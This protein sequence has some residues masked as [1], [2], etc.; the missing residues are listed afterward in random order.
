MHGDKFIV[1]FQTD[2]IEVKNITNNL[3]ENCLIQVNNLF[4]KDVF[5]Q[6]C[7]FLPGQVKT[8]DMTTFNFLDR[9]IDE[10]FYVNVYHNY[11]LSYSKT[12]NDKTKCYVLLSNKNFEKLTE[13]LIE[14]LTRYSNAD[15]LHYTVDYVSEI[16]HTNLKNIEF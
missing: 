14:G 7:D 4:S 2:K 9:Y 12:F 5:K 3:L 15:I 6:V 1:K 10:I 11:K 13:Q 8:F 16:S